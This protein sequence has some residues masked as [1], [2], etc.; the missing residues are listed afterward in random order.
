MT[1]GIINENKGQ[2]EDRYE[3]LNRHNLKKESIKS[4]VNK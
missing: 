4:K 2:K 1:S 3:E